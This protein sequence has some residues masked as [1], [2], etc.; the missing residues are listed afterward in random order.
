MRRPRLLLGLLLVGGL[1]G[2]GEVAAGPLSPARAA[3][4]QSVQL[5]WRERYPPR[6]PHLVFGVERL[7]VTTEG[8]SAVVSIQNATRIRFELGKHPLQLAFGLMLLEDG[9]LE[10]LEEGSR[11]GAL[12]PLREAVEIVPPPPA[13]LAPAQTWRATIS[14]PGSL[15][16]DAY[17]R[18]SFGTL[19]ATGDPLDEIPPNLIWITDKAYRL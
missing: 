17:V 8:W 13:V 16:D 14:A 9:S 6:G 10:A 19:V 4:P 3:E 12:P 7:E 2:C 5:D 11:S 15:A 18:V 1:A